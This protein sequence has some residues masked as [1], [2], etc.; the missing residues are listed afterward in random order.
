MDCCGIFAQEI[1]RYKLIAGVGV[2]ITFIRICQYVFVNRRVC[3]F[4]TTLFCF[5]QR[6]ETL[7]KWTLCLQ[8]PIHS[9][10]SRGIRQTAV[11]T[12]CLGGGKRVTQEIKQVSHFSALLPN[13]QKENYYHFH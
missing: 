10:V 9:P 11:D 12:A 7:S 6:A 5:F 4:S 8:G 2:R 3:F 13:V 1:R